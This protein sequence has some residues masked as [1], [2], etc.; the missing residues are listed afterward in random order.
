MA[1]LQKEYKEVIGARP[2]AANELQRAKNSATLSLPGRWETA[3]A[4]AG[5]LAEQI[6]FALPDEYWDGYA[7]KVNAV[8]LDEVAAAARQAVKPEQLTW[9]VVG[10]R[11]VI[12]PDIEKLGLGDIELI[13][14]DGSPLGKA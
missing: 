2:P 13:D 9:I 6:R 11:A 5:A 8:T 1:E 4:V 14:A 12:E 3:R 7:D 10:D